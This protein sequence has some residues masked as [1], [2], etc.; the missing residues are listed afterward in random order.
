MFPSDIG[1]VIAHAESIIAVSKMLLLET[2]KGATPEEISN[3]E[4]AIKGDLQAIKELV[5]E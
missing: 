1:A 3:M 5:G 2:P 4:K